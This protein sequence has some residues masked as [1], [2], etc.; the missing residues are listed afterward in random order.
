MSK[1]S[2]EE[3]KKIGGSS[4]APVK[5]IE[6]PITVTGQVDK[7]H[8]DTLLD[9]KRPDKV[10]EAGIEQADSKKTLFETAATDAA[11]V[12]PTQKA[13]LDQIKTRIDKT[14]GDISVIKDELQTPDIH[15]QPY[16]KQMRSK[17]SHIDE[18]L[19]IALSKA[20]SEVPADDAVRASD[21]FNPVEKFIGRLSHI[22]Y[23]MED[24]GNYLSYMAENG[25]EISAANMLAIQIK[26]THIG[27]EVEF[28]AGLLS[29]ALEST[30]TI[31][32]VQV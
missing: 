32:N 1:E 3:I 14:L 18:S 11:K 7:A 30:K 25:K 24:M 29:K 2:I 31:M 22:E 15:I 21:T 6:E 19:K 8:F 16:K 10:A 5:H 4:A 12:D 20:G 23:Q 28:F 17:L 27:Q 13:S 26:V 9:Q